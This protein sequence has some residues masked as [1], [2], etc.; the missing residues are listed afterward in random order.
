MK[1]V[2]DLALIGFFSLALLF[3]DAAVEEDF[4]P[5]GTRD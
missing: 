1:L 2:F 5:V 3:Q 4:Q